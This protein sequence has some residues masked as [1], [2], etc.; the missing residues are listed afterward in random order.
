MID[1]GRHRFDPIANRHKE[2]DEMKVLRRR[3]A[4]VWIILWRWFRAIIVGR[5][6]FRLPVRRGVIGCQRLQH[7]FDGVGW[8]RV[9]L[10]RAKQADNPHRGKC[11][12]ETMIHPGEMT[13][14][15]GQYQDDSKDDC[16]TKAHVIVETRDQR[17]EFHGG[18]LL[19]RSG[20]S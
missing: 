9:T 11:S 4:G 15:A 5:P 16:H 2:A 8:D 13:Y 19:L 20:G 1:N 6:S 10:P 12:H 18:L 3:R 17:I 14:S 7:F